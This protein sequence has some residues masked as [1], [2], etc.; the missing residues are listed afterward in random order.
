M[1][2]DCPICCEYYNNSTRKSVRCEFGDC[3]YTACKTCVRQYLLGTTSDPHCM[4]CKKA[5]SQNFMVMKLN[6]SF[7]TTDY[8]K[9]RSSL[10]IQREISKLPETMQLATT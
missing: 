9:H 3:N 10:L 6:R 8:K 1:A 2:A 4:N 5:W 7:I